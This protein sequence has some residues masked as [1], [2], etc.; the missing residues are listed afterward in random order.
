MKSTPK[1]MIKTSSCT[2]QKVQ[3]SCVKTVKQKNPKKS[4]RLIKASDYL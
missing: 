2:E 1:K 3:Q 4:Q